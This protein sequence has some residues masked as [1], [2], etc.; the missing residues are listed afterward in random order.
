MATDIGAGVSA[1][2]A[3]GKVWRW[4]RRLVTA[5]V[6]LLLLMVIAGGIAYWKLMAAPRS[7]EPYKMALELVKNDPKAIEQLG[8][9]IEQKWWPPP[10]GEIDNDPEHGR[11]HLGFEVQGLK[12]KATV[13]VD[14]RRIDGKWGVTLLEVTPEGGRRFVVNA[15]AESGLEEAP[16]FNPTPKPDPKAPPEKPQ[17]I[18]IQVPA[19]E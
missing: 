2:K 8:G 3:R 12:A 4:V 1:T 6:V 13:Q 17:D 10:S 9:A 16:L 15:G 11:A 5:L 14:A 7:S 18:Q 19:P